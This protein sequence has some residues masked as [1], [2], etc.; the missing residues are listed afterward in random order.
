MSKFMTNDDVIKLFEEIDDLKKNKEISK[1][2]LNKEI[3]RIHD[4]IIKGLSFLC[5]AIKSSEAF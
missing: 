5:W 1:D 4:T 3:S 2:E